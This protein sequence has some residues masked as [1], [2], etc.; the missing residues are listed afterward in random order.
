MGV[1][2]KRTKWVEL[3]D[4]CG[5]LQARFDP[6][7]WQLSIKQRGQTTVYDLTRYLTQKDAQNTGSL[8]ANETV[9]K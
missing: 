1:A 5:Q 8:Q 6:Q 4:P 3:R 2:N 7:G 9:L